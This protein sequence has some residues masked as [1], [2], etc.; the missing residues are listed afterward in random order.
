MYM[1]GGKALSKRTNR[2][3]GK[4]THIKW[5]GG[6]AIK[7]YCEG[8]ERATLIDIVNDSKRAAQ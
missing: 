4:I 3:L 6:H 2:D 8:I 5:G 7:I 1:M